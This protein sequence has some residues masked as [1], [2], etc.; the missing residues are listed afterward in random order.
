MSPKFGLTSLPPLQKRGG[1]A[2]YL[3][4]T[5]YLPHQLY[6]STHHFRRDLILL[7]FSGWRRTVLHCKSKLHIYHSGLTSLPPLQKRGGGAS[8]QIQA[9]YLPHQ[10]WFFT[11]HFRKVRLQSASPK[12]RGCALFLSFGEVR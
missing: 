3:I 12:S 7:S 10:I 4:Q 9:S 8:M 6:I 1:G 11:H 5:S 2:V